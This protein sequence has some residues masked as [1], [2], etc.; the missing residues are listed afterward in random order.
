MSPE[1][2]AE[3]ATSLR[4]PRYKRW[5]SGWDACDC[6]GLIVLYWREVLGRELL[7]EPALA[8]GM[9]DGFSALG[10]H[11]DLAPPTPGACGFMAWEGEL[12]RHCG[13]LLPRGDLLHTEPPSPVG[14]GG[15]RAT[16]LTALARLYP[17]VRFYAPRPSAFSE[18]SA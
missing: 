7:P 8:S 15:P 11:W 13:V 6:Y 9:A 1:E 18:N 5:A 12:P 14:A 2:F 3:R 10:M 4:A 17:D 16:R